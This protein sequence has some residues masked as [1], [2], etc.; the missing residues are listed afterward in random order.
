V[1]DY[2]SPGDIQAVAKQVK[3]TAVRVRGETEL[4]YIPI[5]PHNPLTSVYRRYAGT[6]P[7]QGVTQFPYGVGPDGTYLG[8]DAQWS[9]LD[10]EYSWIPDEFNRR[11]DP[12]PSNFDPLIA[13]MHSTALT[14]YNSSSGAETVGAVNREVEKVLAGWV[15]YANEVFTN[16]FVNRIPDVAKNQ[17]YFAGMLEQAMVANK[18][19][20]VTTRKDLLS[21]GQQAV[22]A[23][24]STTQCLGANVPLIL[25]VAAAVATVAVGVASIPLTG[26][27]VLAPAGVAAFTII[28]GISSGLSQ[29]HFPAPQKLDLGA[30][31][32]DGVLSKMIDA[33]VN[34]D[35][36]IDTNERTIV[37]GLQTNYTALTDSSG[38]GGDQTS[39]RDAFLAPRPNPFL[40]EVS[41]GQYTKDG[42]FEPL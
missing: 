36:H 40:S 2:P 19:I 5:D 33:I 38:G 22:T 39:S 29:A 12:E 20:F 7:A 28:A 42:N 35:R 9:A 17:A 1:A 6:K 16:N 26:G 10:A 18:D 32:V 37:G 13:E 15:G 11:I 4:H 30:D 14:L 41:S 3:D 23:L 24:D 8:T 25:T 31:S 27:A 34:I 21:T